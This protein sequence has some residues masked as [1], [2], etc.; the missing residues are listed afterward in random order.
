MA[1]P[2]AT[3]PNDLPT[4][5][6]PTFPRDRGRSPAP[7]PCVPRLASIA[8]S[9]LPGR[10]SVT[11]GV[12]RAIQLFGREWP[13][14]RATWMK[15]DSRLYAV[16]PETPVERIMEETPTAFGAL[17]RAILHQQVSISAGRAIVV[18]LA[19]AC[20]GRLEPAEVL[21]L[22]ED[23]LRAAGLSRQKA[24]YVRCL[25]AA[26][27]AGALDGI[28]EQPDGAVIERLVRLSGIGV[29]TAKMF[30]IFH[31]QRPDC[32]SGEDFGL[33]EGIRI[34]DQRAVQPDPRAAEE[35][36]ECWRPFRSVAAV[37]LWDLVRRTRGN[38]RAPPVVAKS[39]TIAEPA[40]PTSNNRN[41]SL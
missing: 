1:P 2:G 31:L 26:A 36:A 12:I 8:Q 5:I 29:W 21:R 9:A 40:P 37:V 39:G 3:G 23:Q 28:E 22:S 24:H 30:C 33:R 20:H 17:V 16:T 14:A 6:D 19:T 7:R 27:V 13:E 11:R 10:G 18:R 4:P 38:R 25:A 15:T 32:F 41:R 35:R 34:L